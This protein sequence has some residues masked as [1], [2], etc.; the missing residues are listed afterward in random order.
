MSHCT[1]VLLIEDNPIAQR[2]AALLLKQLH[3]MVDIAGTGGQALQLIQSHVYH[4][5]LMDLGLPDIDGVTLT[6]TIKQEQTHQTIPIVA[7]TAHDTY[8]DDC[9][10]AGMIDYL[11]KPLTSAHCQFILEKYVSTYHVRKTGT[12][13]TDSR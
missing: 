10:R 1:R 5:I 8:R 2:F 3:C 6:K 12:K 7:L 4:L 13:T 11:V 9:S